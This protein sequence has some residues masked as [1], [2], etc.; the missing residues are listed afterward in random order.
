LLDEKSLGLPSWRA[1]KLKSQANRFGFKKLTL[2]IDKLAKF[3]Y[4]AKTGGGDVV[5]LLDLALAEI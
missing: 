5:T 4:L 1:S 2:L 3:D